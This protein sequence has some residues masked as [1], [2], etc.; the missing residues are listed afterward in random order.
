MN[1]LKLMIIFCF[2]SYASTGF[3]LYD[4]ESDET[5][6]DTGFLQ[7][8]ANYDSFAKD[9]MEI[10][11]S[12]RNS[13]RSDRNENDQNLD[14]K[15]DCNKTFRQL[16]AHMG[17]A[18]II[19]WYHSNLHKVE[20]DW[21]KKLR[22]DSVSDFL[23]QGHMSYILEEE[24]EDLFPISAMMFKSLK[25]LPYQKSMIWQLHALQETHFFEYYIIK[26]M[27]QSKENFLS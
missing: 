16:V 1:Y 6:Y 3:S 24:A 7:A 21:Y 2:A 23:K 9:A 4:D 26:Q 12:V 27:E 17:Y 8:K 14:K 5:T 18:S 19:S 13:D 11:N 25:N 22:I 10:I 15:F 20:F